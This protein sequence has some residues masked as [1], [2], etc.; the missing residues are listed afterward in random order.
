MWRIQTPPFGFGLQQ[1]LERHRQA[2]ITGTSAAGLFHA[3]F[4]RG[5]GRF[6]WIGRSQMHPVRRRIVE[7]G[8]QFGLVLGVTLHPILCQ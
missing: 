3:L 7:I 1:E 6:H 8:Q 2:S 5:K 4:D